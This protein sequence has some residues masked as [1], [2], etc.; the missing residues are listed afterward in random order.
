MT[1]PRPSGKAE[2]DDARRA[3][4][5]L[6]VPSEPGNKRLVMERVAEAVEELGLPAQRLERLKTAVAEATMNAMEHGNR[7]NPEVPA[8]SR[9]S[10]RTRTSW[11]AS[12]TKAKPR[13]GP[14]QEGAGPGGQAEGSAVGFRQRNLERRSRT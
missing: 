5:E 13:P 7:Y 1:A 11:C 2:Q 14:Q 12:P 3:L 4:A 8:R 10:L 9:C 6:S